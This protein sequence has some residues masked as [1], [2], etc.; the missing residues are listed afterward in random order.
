MFLL[1]IYGADIVLGVE[2][3]ATL[4]RIVFN[5]DEIYMEFHHQNSTVILH[6][7]TEPSRIAQ[8]NLSQMQKTTKTGAIA[9]L[10]QL[11]VSCQPVSITTP[12]NSKIPGLQQNSSR[13]LRESSLLNSLLQE[14]KPVFDKPSG[15]PPI[16]G[17]EHHIPLLP[18][19][20]TVNVCPYR[21]PHFQKSEMEKLISDMLNDG[22]IRP[23]CSPFSSPVLL[24]K[25]KDGTWRFCVDYRALNSVTIRDRFPIPTVD[26]L[27][28]ELRGACVFSKLDLRSGYHQLRMHTDDVFKTAFRTHDGHYEFTVM[29]FGL[30]NAPSSF[31]AAMNDLFRPVLRRYVL[32]FFDDI[33]VYSG[34]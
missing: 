10:L 18:G 1:P 27:L 20:K 30:T 24:V 28:D 26:E 5:Y 22:I 8:L 9:T 31:Q 2:W 4:G 16:R 17:T 29:P 15:L 21:Y 34:T 11:T 33:L 12:S 6:G 14:F 13:S 3:L 25:K 23:S 7:L 32:V 19:T